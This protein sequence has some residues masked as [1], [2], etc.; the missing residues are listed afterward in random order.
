[1]HSVL[2]GSL[3]PRFTA[4][5]FHLIQFQCTLCFGVLFNFNHRRNHDHPSSFN[6]L[7]ALGF[8][9][10]IPVTDGT[11]IL[12]SFNALCALGFSST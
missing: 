4:P 5:P 11:E 12:T 10:T 7:C 8:S 6:A 2:W 3:Q 1:M 9:S